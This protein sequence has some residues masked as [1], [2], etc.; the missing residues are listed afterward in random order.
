MAAPQNTLTY[1]T[2]TFPFAGLETDSQT[3]YAE[4]QMTKV[5][6][7]YT[8]RISG[9]IGGISQSDLQNKIQQMQDQ[10]RIPRQ[11]FK[12]NWAGDGGSVDLFKYFS[13]AG[14]QSD[15][16]Q[17]IDWG[18]KP[19]ELRFTRFPGGRAAAY[20]WRVSVTAMDKNLATSVLAVTWQFGHHI[21]ASGFTTRTVTG[22]IL[23]EAG[24]VQ[25]GLSADHYRAIVS[26]AVPALTW[27]KFDQATY[28]QSEDGRVLSFSVTETEQF[29]TFPKPITDGHVSWTVVTPGLL[30]GNLMCTYTLSGWI[31][32]S[33]KYS[34][35]LLLDALFSLASVRFGAISGTQVMGERMIRETLF[36]RNRIDFLLSAQAPVGTATSSD[37][38]FN[39][40]VAGMESFGIR[41]PG[42]DGAPMQINPYG[43]TD[44]LSS[45][46][47]AP[48][49]NLYDATTNTGDYQFS[50]ASTN[51]NNTGVL[52]QSNRPT[53]D[54]S[55]GGNPVQNGISDRHIENPIVEFH[56]K[57]SY[58]FYNHVVTLMPKK[59]GLDPITQQTSEPLA[60]I[61]QAGYMS[62]VAAKVA[63][64]ESLANDPVYDGIHYAIEQSYISVPVAEPIGDGSINK[65]TTE[66]RYILVGKKNVINDNSDFVLPLDPRRKLPKAEAISNG[67]LPQLTEG[68]EMQQS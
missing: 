11:T 56:E 54:S 65:Y 49:P 27:F 12:V 67:D 10:L 43:Q 9:W 38:T 15:A 47:V 40:T 36:G 22:K 52:Q 35:K 44:D 19:G 1:G 48:S 57:I 7:G 45:G 25:A 21:D 51:P 31:E 26:N 55:P 53:P 33:A 24:S 16:A 30:T 62:Q 23:I 6:V 32:T 13:E 3:L 17:D 59:S 46:S 58:E 64:L 29:W 2:F 63:D 14:R 66:W 41:P 60:R 50:A 68:S 28:V 4:D 34:K 5:G 61:I 37:T 39:F 8:F 18:P 20:Q 42:V